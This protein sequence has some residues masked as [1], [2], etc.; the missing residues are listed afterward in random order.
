[1]N[2]YLCGRVGT[3]VRAGICSI[4]LDADS[5]RHARADTAVDCFYGSL[6]KS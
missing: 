6:L 4:Y 3:P 5:M 2:N 1:M